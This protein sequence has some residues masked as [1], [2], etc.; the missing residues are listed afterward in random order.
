VTPRAP[1]EKRWVVREGDGRTVAEIVRR[2]GE[3][4]RAVAE[5]RVFVGRRRVTSALE[6][7]KAGDEVR[8]GGAST[9]ASTST[10]GWGVI[11]EREGLLACFKPAGMPTVPDH[12]GASH[13]L[14]ALA[15]ASIGRSASD[16][17]V[18]SRLDREVSGVV[19]LATT[20]EAETRLKLA[21]EQGRYTRRYVALAVADTLIK[22]ATS[23]D[24]DRPNQPRN[25]WDAPI[26]RGKDPRHRAANGPDA[27]VA[28][29]HWAM[30]ARAGGFAL[31]AVE[32][33]T[34][35]TH[36]IRIHASHA[37]APL[38]GDRDYGG[39]TR[40]SLP[41]GRVVALA[42]IALH[43]AR[44][45][46]PG[47]RGEPLVASAP[48]PAELVRAWTGLGGASEAWDTAVSCVLGT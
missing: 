24:V 9:N 23:I 12:A 36:Q 10:S 1:R 47:A 31:L 21:R 11:W 39:P 42:R 8:I 25:V 17:L 46:V 34:G 2:A 43:A 16:M 22:T 20:A 30:V 41:D 35:R 14:V 45:S 38:L 19:V 26:G 29:T 5:G 27:K 32:P 40:T 37:G 6:A 3:E 7:V 18:T 44:V 13:T 15:A 4:E 48:V 28:T 33:Q